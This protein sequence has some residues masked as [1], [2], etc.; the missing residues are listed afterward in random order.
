MTRNK[1]L[2]AA[3][4]GFA[5]VLATVASLS[6]ARALTNC[7]V[8][9]ADL[10]VD[11][12]EAQMLVLVNDYRAANGLNPLTL[13][14][15]VTRG[16]AWFSRDMAAN[17][18][19]PYNHVDRFGRDIFTRLTH[20]EAGFTT[21]AE[22]IAA[23]N[24][25]A[26]ATFEQWRTSPSHN[27]VMLLS[28]VT[29]AGIA[30]SFNA[31]ATYGWYWTLDL[32][33]GSTSATSPSTTSAPT[34]TVAL[35]PPTTTPPTTVAPPTTLGSTGSTPPSSTATDGP[36]STND[37][38]A[39][40]DLSAPSDVTEPADVPGRTDLPDTTTSALTAPALLPSVCAML[41][42]LGAETGG[43]MAA[44]Q[45][46]FG[47]TFGLG[48]PSTLVA[49]LEEVRDRITAD[50]DAARA[51]VGCDQPALGGL[52]LITAATAS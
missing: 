30:R 34:T 8:S 14:T 51:A 24:A 9:A 27:A 39:T 37:R 28:G 43:Q 49:H 23:G 20:C 46:A 38:G 6:P 31:T 22:N 35:P 4:A 52:N 15:N 47:G 33:N 16:A 19:F 7:N 10:A 40:T 48:P 36:A 11:D 29:S 41:Q 26:E 17:N 13:E 50:I 45:Q 18:Y 32:T 12:E 5:F 42:A 1:Q 3:L 44:V 21:W 25:S 2:G